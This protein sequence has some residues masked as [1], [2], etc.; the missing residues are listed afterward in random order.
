MDSFN[1]LDLLTWLMVDEAKRSVMEV[2]SQLSR[3]DQRLEDIAASVPLPAASR[4]VWDSGHP[5]AVPRQLHAVIKQVRGD[6]L[7]DA[8]AALSWAAQQTPLSLWLEAECP[9]V[10]RGRSEIR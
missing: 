10:D 2:V 1:V 8:I 3:L 6:Y 5:L 9:R 4:P 7:Q